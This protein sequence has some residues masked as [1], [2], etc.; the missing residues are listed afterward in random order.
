MTT[1]TIAIAAAAVLLFSAATVSVAGLEGRW[2]HVRVQDHGDDGE[3]VNIN[4]P[5][6]LVES[7]LPTIQ[8]DEFSGG[9]IVLDDADLEG[10]DLHA[11]LSA[12]RDTPDGEFVT[13][14]SRDESVRVAKEAG[15]LVVL[16]EES[17]NESVRIQMPLTVVD[18]MLASG[19]NE[20]DLLAGLHALADF[21]GGDLITVKSD[22]SF[23]RIWIDSSEDGD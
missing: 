4:L 5:L 1:K 9:R 7:L 22:D 6:Q 13:V 21:D 2:F 15:F 17:D 20:L 19:G 16:A 10:I 11:I 14:R 3:F 18:A 12:L 23:V 8:T